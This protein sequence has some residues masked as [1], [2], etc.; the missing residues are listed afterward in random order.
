MGKKTRGGG[1]V[2]GYIEGRAGRRALELDEFWSELL[3]LHPRPSPARHAFRYLSQGIVA[4]DLMKVV[5]S[6]VARANC[7]FTRRLS[8]RPLGEAGHKGLQQEVHRRGHDRVA[9]NG[10]APA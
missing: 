5:A 8:T 4:I 9:V 10:E 7:M 6:G 1:P 3:P 2:L